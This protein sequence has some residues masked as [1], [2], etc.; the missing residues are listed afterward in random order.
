MD[1]IWIDGTGHG[2]TFFKPDNVVAQNTKI[3]SE[4][5]T[6]DNLLYN[7]DFRLKD[8]SGDFKGWTKSNGY[9]FEFYKS[10]VEEG[11]KSA[12]L[13]KNII[14]LDEDPQIYPRIKQSSTD[15]AQMF[16]NY[17]FPP[18]HSYTLSFVAAV[19]NRAQDPDFVAVNQ[20]DRN[21]VLNGD[22]SHGQRDWIS[23]STQFTSGDEDVLFEEPVIHYFN[24]IYKGWFG[25]T[26]MGSSVWQMLKYNLIQNRSYFLAFEAFSFY[27][28]CTLNV[29]IIY[30]NRRNE[31]IRDYSQQVSIL[32]DYPERYVLPVPYPSNY[33][34]SDIGAIEVR[35]ERSD[36]VFDDANTPM[37]GVMPVL[38]GEPYYIYFSNVVLS[39]S[40]FDTEYWWPADEDT[41]IIRSSEPNR[42]LLLNSRSEFGLSNWQLTPEDIESDPFPIASNSRILCLVKN[43]SIK[44][45][46]NSF[47]DYGQTYYLTAMIRRTASTVGTTIGSAVYVFSRYTGEIIGDY[48][49]S[50]SISAGP[51]GY[52]PTVLLSFKLDDLLPDD[53][54]PV[55][56]IQIE[57]ACTGDENLYLYG[58]VLNQDDSVV[59][60]TPAP[61]DKGEIIPSFSEINNLV[62]DGRSLTTRLI[63]GENE[64]VDHYQLNSD[65][66]KYTKTF[67]FDSEPS[68]FELYFEWGNGPLNESDN[69]GY[70]T[71]AILTNIKMEVGDTASDWKISNYEYDPNVERPYVNTWRDWHIVPNSRPVMNPPAPKV[72]YVD[73]PGSNNSI[74]LTEVLTG[75]V[76]YNSREGSFEFLVDVSKWNSWMEAYTTIMN[77]LHGQRMD[78]I[79][80]DEPGYYYSGRFTVNEWKSAKDGSSITIDYVVD[81]Y[82]YELSSTIDNWLWDPFNFETGIARDYSNITVNRYL[83]IDVGGSDMPVVPS[84]IVTSIQ[85]SLVVNWKGVDYKL[86]TGVVHVPQIVIANNDENKLIFKGNGTLSIAFKGGKL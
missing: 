85:D 27:V 24:E 71:N 3:E 34:P 39:Q 68:S 16:D 44:Q 5:I 59:S 57:I 50:A 23:E 28:D 49:S 42:N 1:F 75:N 14:D 20:F 69:T 10:D 60:W 12:L 77:Y 84:F 37:D 38:E 30:Y 7:S 86:S 55:G 79:L 35:F 81:A 17:V 53:S 70:L 43:Q 36:T 31:V 66:T 82:K 83:S 65:L 26:Y 22:F 11:G 51:A 29:H 2:M 63:A 48:Y 46:L 73:I 62:L 72:N 4:Q 6:R 54:D 15:L 61:E 52:I 80:D 9:E 41:P 56:A 18:A 58:L 33:I 76:K 64:Y 25:L 19:N 8:S 47:P 40:A 32:N 13:A 78:L 45:S 21:L 74:D 67:N